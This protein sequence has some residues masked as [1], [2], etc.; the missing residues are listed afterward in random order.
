MLEAL[1]LQL[2]YGSITW[3]ALKIVP[4]TQSALSKCQL[5]LFILW[6][7][8]FPSRNESCRNTQVCTKIMY[9]SIHSSRIHPLPSASTATTIS[10][11][12]NYNSFIPGL[13]ASTLAPYNL[14]PPLRKRDLWKQIMPLSSNCSMVP[15]ASS[16][17]TAL[18]TAPISGSSYSSGC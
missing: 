2:I 10:H 11:L 7:S 6:C 5:L 17:P 4:G 18:W 8:N 9:K 1:S 3:K 12:Q 14:L 16:L 15:C 13:P